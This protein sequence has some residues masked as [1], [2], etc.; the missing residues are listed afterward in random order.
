MDLQ[1]PFEVVTPTLDGAVLATLALVDEPFTV[2]QMTRMI[3]AS[4]EGIRRVLR[5]LVLHGIVSVKT[6]GSTSTFS[7]NREH[8][9]APAIIAIAQLKATFLERL[10]A[11]LLKWAI[12]PVYAAVFGSTAR[13]EMTPASDIDLLVVRPDDVDEEQWLDQVADL[14]TQVTGW[15]GNETRVLEYTAGELGGTP[16]PVLR[17]VVRDGLTVAGS[18][19][20]FRRQVGAAGGS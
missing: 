18:P 8:L 15:T 10:E 19:A 6:Y 20:W 2:G 5:R 1:D 11:E 7:L 16:E 9:A 3:D 14:S 4:D 17:D 13:G 12:P